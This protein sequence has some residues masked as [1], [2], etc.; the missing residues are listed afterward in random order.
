MTTFFLFLPFSLEPS[1]KNDLSLSL[2]IKRRRRGIIT[3]FN[4]QE[5]KIIHTWLSVFSEKRNSLSA[6]IKIFILI[7]DEK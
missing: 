2:Q 4:Y 6:W 5:A 1:Y 7:R 3:F